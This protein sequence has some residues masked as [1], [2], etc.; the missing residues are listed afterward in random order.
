[1]RILIFHGYL[2][3]G[4]GSNIY[5]AS[6][7][8]AFARLGHEVELLCQDR[9]WD[10]P[11]G[12]T[13]RNPDI[14]RVLPVYVADR[15]EGFDAK[16][17][18]QLSDSELDHYLAAN[19]AAVQDA[20]TPDVALANH[21]VMGPAILARGLADGAPYAVKIHG[22]ALE[23][24]VRPHRER[25]LPYALEGVRG[26]AGVLVGSRHT[27]ESLWEVLADEPTLPESTRLGPPGVD[28]HHFRPGVADLEH[29]ASRVR[30]A[31]TASWG[32]EAGAA[33][34]LLSLDPAEDRIVSY[35]GKLIVSKGVDLLLAAWPLVVAQ[36]PEARLV[37]VGFGT[38]RETLSRFVEAL[39]R[40]DVEDLRDIAA[41]GRELEGGPP[42]ELKYLNAF[43]DGAGSDWLAAAPAAAGRV[44]FTGRLE[45]DDLPDLLPACEAQVMPSTFP[46]S[47]GM[48]A[49][50]AAAC[51]ALPLSA[52]HSG[53]AEVTATLAPAL[54]PELQPLLSF[55]VGPDSVRQ[56]AD[57][58]VTWLTL[59][60]AVR[61][62]AR[63]A[64]AAQAAARY[65][66]ESVAEGVIAAAQ[67]RLDALPHPAPPA[68]NV[69]AP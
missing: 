62:R 24:T 68:D 11:E 46:E 27:A 54:D 12:V 48:V 33:D 31:D 44:H 5:N 4:T 42:G 35:V 14:G 23:Y 47:F 58:L 28:V 7:V 21:L 41:R 53:M 45:H 60:P 29:L 26:A 61:E 51:G 20:Q 13:V 43:L 15:Y 59:D 67:G 38:Y 34:A 63:A 9:D 49:A 1:M 6:L 10:A 55:E 39:E 69:P 8:R 30:S 2:L 66:W 57:K 64:L 16:P 50:E 40:A 17:Y 37:I 25:F 52:G 19:V 32:G 3:R 56:I 65:S 36:V 18:P 22:S